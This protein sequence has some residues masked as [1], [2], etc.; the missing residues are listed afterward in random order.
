MLLY[1]EHIVSRPLLQ[2]ETSSLDSAHIGIC[3]STGILTFD[4]E[5]PSPKIYLVGGTQPQD[6]VLKS[7]PTQ[8]LTGIYHGRHFCPFWIYSGC[9]VC[10]DASFISINTNAIHLAVVTVTGPVD[11]WRNTPYYKGNALNPNPPTA[12]QQLQGDYNRMQVA[13]MKTLHLFGRRSQREA[14]P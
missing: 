7:G 12:A 4:K 10:Q 2:P 3:N 8:S 1:I 14:L 9:V 5:T 13:E 6:G 11:L